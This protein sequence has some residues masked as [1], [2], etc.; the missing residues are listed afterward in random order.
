LLIYYT[1]LD[2]TFPC[3][4]LG[5]KHNGTLNATCTGSKSCRA[6]PPPRLRVARWEIK[7]AVGEMLITPASAPA[8]S[9]ERTLAAGWA[10]R[11]GHGSHGKKINIFVG[12]KP[13]LKKNMSH[14]AVS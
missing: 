13:A 6:F 14:K 5:L 4:F 8:A 11:T 3:V 2:V 9:G 1:C 7:R 10:K 12:N